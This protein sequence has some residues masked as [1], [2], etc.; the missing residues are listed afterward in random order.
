MSHRVNSKHMSKLNYE[1]SPKAASP[2][3]ACRARMLVESVLKENERPFEGIFYVWRKPTGWGLFP[4]RFDEF[5]EID[6]CALWSY[7]V[8]PV[9]AHLWAPKL[10]RPARVVAELIEN[11]PYG[12]PRG[13]IS[14]AGRGYL[15]LHGDD[16]GEF[17]ARGTVE[18][19][20]SL[21]G[22][23]KWDHD[24]HEVCSDFDKAQLRHILKIR[25][26]W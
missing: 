2:L 13:R 8:V 18:K 10:K 11:L 16:F 7:H 22:T 20:F 17:C 19:A 12:F 5:P 23:A 14:K 15:V 9:L 6:H 25:E 4:Y 1:T 24:D 3:V 26:N 21:N